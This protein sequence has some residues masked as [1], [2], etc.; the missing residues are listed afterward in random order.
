MMLESAW[1]SCSDDQSF[2]DVLKARRTD[3]KAKLDENLTSASSNGHSG[4]SNLPGANSAT[5]AEVVG[6][7]TQLIDNFRRV[8][9]FLLNCAKNGLDAFVVAGNGAW[10]TPLNNATNPAVTVET[11]GDWTAVAN[12]Y[13]VDPG[14]IVGKPVSDESIYVWMMNNLFP[15]T[16]ARSDYSSAIVGRGGLQFT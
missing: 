4:T 3:A 13:D 1:D 12:R 5:D 10:P 15:I 7:W 8:R 6:G 11:S 14:K 2:L 9:E 16:E